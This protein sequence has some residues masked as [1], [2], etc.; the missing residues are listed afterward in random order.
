[1]IRLYFYIFIT[2]YNYIITINK[3]K[4]LSFGL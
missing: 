1:M 3:K 4:T 2:Q